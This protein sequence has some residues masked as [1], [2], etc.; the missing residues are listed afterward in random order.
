MRVRGKIPNVP[1][2]IVSDLNQ[3][4][5]ASIVRSSDI[6]VVPY[7]R[8]GFGRVP[9]EAMLADSAVATYRSSGPD[10]LADGDNALVA[11]DNRADRLLKCVARIIRDGELKRRLKAGGRATTANYSQEKQNEDLVAFYSPLG[12][13]KS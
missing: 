13:F 8:E 7:T 1:I 12:F 2:R 10:Y 5:F 11:S 6:V 9:L 3:G 4:V